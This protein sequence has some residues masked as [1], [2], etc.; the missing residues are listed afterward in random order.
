MTRDRQPCGC[1]CVRCRCTSFDGGPCA[2]C[3][4]GLHPAANRPQLL[5]ALGQWTEALEQTRT[6]WGNGQ[7]P[8]RP[9]RA[10]AVFGEPAS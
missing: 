6:S 9:D 5:E 4:Q 8:H 1:S 7:G 10:A 3:R 2:M